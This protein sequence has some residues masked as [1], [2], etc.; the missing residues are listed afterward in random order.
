[1]L[2]ILNSIEYVLEFIREELIFL[3]HIITDW[4]KDFFFCNL[5]TREF[6]LLFWFLKIYLDIYKKLNIWI[7][8][9]ISLG[10]ACM[11]NWKNVCLVSSVCWGH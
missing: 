7:L 2:S 1:M 4:S 3:S 11:Y 8:F 10:L 5:R 6:I 9:S